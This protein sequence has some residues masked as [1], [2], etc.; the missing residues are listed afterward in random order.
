MG[1][2]H[3]IVNGL[4]IGLLG[5]H[6]VRCNGVQIGLSNASTD[7]R[8][9][10]LGLWNRNQSRSLPFINW[11]FK[12]DPMG[13]MLVNSEHTAE[14]LVSSDNYFVN[15]HVKRY[16]RNTNYFGIIAGIGF[17]ATG[18]WM[19]NE[20]FNPDFHSSAREDRHWKRGLIGTSL[21]FTLTSIFFDRA[22]R[23]HLI[24]GIELYNTLE[25]D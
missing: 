6:D 17:A 3:Y 9:F 4:T 23:K 19:V 10:Q 12:P 20:V 16:R 8:G 7:L 22:A 14:M 2:S 13:A 18:I 24:K 15:R 1:N 11:S 25:K 5:N 21:T